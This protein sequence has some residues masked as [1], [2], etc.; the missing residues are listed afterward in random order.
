M[1][2]LLGTIAGIGTWFS[3][4]FKG[5]LALVGGAP[6]IV[7]LFSVRPDLVAIGAALVLLVVNLVGVKQT[8]RMQ[9]A[10]VGV[11]L[12]A[13]VW[14][15]V[16]SGGAIDAARF[17]G[18]FGERPRSILAA[19]GFI[20][21]SYAGVTKVA[22]IAEEVENPGR[23]I[24][25]GMLGSLGFTTL[26]YVVVVVVI[27]GAA[28]GDEIVGSQT[29]VADVAAT[30]LP[31]V[32]VLTVVLAA[33]LALVSTANA[34]ILSASRYP[35]AM[36]RDNLAPDLLEHVSDRFDTPSAAILLTGGLTLLLIWK[37]PIGDIAKLGSAFKILVFIMANLSLVAFRESD[38]E[39][40][41]PEFEDPLYPWTQAFG[42]IGGLVLLTQMG[43]RFRRSG[44]SS[45]SLRASSG[46]S[47]TSTDGSSA[48]AS[49]ATNSVGVSGSG[50]SIGRRKPSRATARARACWSRSPRTPISTG[51]ALWSSWGRPSRTRG[52]T[53]SPS[54]G[55][56]RCRISSPCSPPGRISRAMTWTSRNGWPT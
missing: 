19:T 46:T 31:E 43:A 42:V 18:F 20:Y 36:S 49:P 25:L 50:R 39:E 29:P 34:G 55:S 12:A 26:M 56:T 32:G 15:I 2:P 30:T 8:G 14:F 10:I 28:P 53:R 5:A 33:V 44:L 54:S 37:V 3:L 35:F 38:I 16:G 11:M 1:G 52:T 40:Y 27:V 21:V 24:P 4:T 9:I 6:Y 41:D 7:L 48:R 51:S 17:Q 47:D 13:M 23:V 22:S 45:S